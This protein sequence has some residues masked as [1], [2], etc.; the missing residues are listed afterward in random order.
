MERVSVISIEKLNCKYIVYG[1][2]NII[3]GNHMHERLLIDSQMSRII[4]T[5]FYNI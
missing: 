4:E 2:S 1:G 5:Q 3:L